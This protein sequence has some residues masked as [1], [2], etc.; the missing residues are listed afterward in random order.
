MCVDVATALCLG[1]LY[2]G[3][4]KCRFGASFISYER[5]LMTLL[6]WDL[7]LNILLLVMCPR[8]VK[9]GFRIDL[10]LC[11]NC[12]ANEVLLIGF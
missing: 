6:G 10:H 8:C 7:L 4:C 11:L 2:V 9:L 12:V 5:A 3:V 1:F